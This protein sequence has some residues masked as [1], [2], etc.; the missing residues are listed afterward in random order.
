MKG[1]NL[2]DSTKLHIKVG[3]LVNEMKTT[4]SNLERIY[5]TVYG[6][7]NGE[8]G[9]VVMLDRLRQSA[10]QSKWITRAIALPVIGTVIIYIIEFFKAH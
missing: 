3:V 8:T 10:N 5:K 1:E 9:H 7:G 2:S 6:D 4:N